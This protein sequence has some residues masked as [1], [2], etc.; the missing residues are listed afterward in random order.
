[1]DHAQHVLSAILPSD[2]DALLYATTRLSREHFGNPT[3]SI[4]FQMIERY[5]EQTGGV[6]PRAALMDL[7]QRSKMDS[8]KILLYAEVY[9]VAAATPVSD[10][11]FRFSVDAMLQLYE[12]HQTG[13]VITTAYEILGSKDGVTEKGSDTPLKG[14]R[15]AQQYLYD[16]LGRIEKLSH[17]EVSP[18]GDMMVESDDI[19]A[20]YLASKETGGVQGVKIGIPTLDKATGG[21]ANGD[22]CLI[23]A[24]TSSGKSQMCAQM[25]WNAAVVQGKN[26][27]FATSETVRNTIIR[28]I[29]ARHSREAMFGYPQGLDS[30]AIKQ[31]TLTVAEEKVLQDVLADL[32]E[33]AKAGRYGRIEVTQMP[34]G[35]TL[36]YMEA[37]MKRHQQMW[38][39]EFA[40]FDYLNLLKSETRRV[41]EREEFNDILK[42]AKNLATSFADGRGV[43]FVSPWQMSRP[44]Y[45]LA[46]QTGYYEIGSLSDTSEAEKSADLIYS[47]LRFMDSPKKA[48]IQGLKCRDAAIPPMIDLDI[49][50]RCSYLGEASSQYANIDMGGM[51]LA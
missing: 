15:D 2:K 46:Q 32:R 51:A 28:R 37:R 14:H 5:F 4:I 17:R 30:N 24:Y 27:F 23:A 47:I 36:S 19:L 6:L 9:D 40:I 7:L 50:F 48:K 3:Q 12:E 49:D 26:T 42:N 1:M 29:V 35:A 45:E 21:V 13:Q 18:E 8:G 25:A 41:S 33:G 22:L 16:H 10:H 44:K 20:T 11:E 39:I 38:D 34:R 31:G 43:P